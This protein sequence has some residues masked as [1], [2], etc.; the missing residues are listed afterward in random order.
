MLNEK[1]LEDAKNQLEPGLVDSGAGAKAVFATAQVATEEKTDCFS[2]DAN[3][4]SSKFSLS[5]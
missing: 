2:T 4:L 1:L 3:K 5:W